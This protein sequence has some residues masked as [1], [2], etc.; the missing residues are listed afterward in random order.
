MNDFIKKRV[1]LS[2]SDKTLSINSG[3]QP[4]N[5]VCISN[6]E[7][8]PQQQFNLIAA[9]DTLDGRYNLKNIF[10]DYKKAVIKDG[11]VV[12]K[13]T[14]AGIEDAWLNTLIY[15]INPSHVRFF[16]ANEIINAGADFFELTEFVSVPFRR[17]Y[18]INSYEKIASLISDFPENVQDKLDIELTDSLLRITLYAGFFIWQNRD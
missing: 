2:E 5:S 1:V 12:L 13:E 9:E 17:E 14:V 7:I 11:L 15:S 6:N 18:S 8:I 10:Q 4:V 3:F 16:T